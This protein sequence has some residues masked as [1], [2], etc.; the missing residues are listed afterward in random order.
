MNQDGRSATMTAPHGPSQQECIR[1]SLAQ[2]G[3]EA[4]Q[5]TVAE[6]HGTGT[7]LGD[8]IEVNALRRVVSDRETPMPVTSSKTFIA[9]QEA[10]AGLAGIGKC[11]LMLLTSAASPNQHLHYLNSHLDTAGFP[12]FFEDELT[13]YGTPEGLAGVSSF[14]SGG[15]NGRAD[16]WGR[17][18]YGE[19][20]TTDVTSGLAL[21]ARSQ[22]YERICNGE[23]AR[24]WARVSF[25]PGSCHHDGVSMLVMTRGFL[26]DVAEHWE[27]LRMFVRC[28]CVRVCRHV[29]FFVFVFLC[30]Y[31]YVNTIQTEKIYIYTGTHGSIH[32]QLYIF[33][34]TFRHSFMCTF[35]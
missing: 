28:V 18:L 33:T 2:S 30:T 14:G 24:G 9:H 17:C 4:N 19:R 6:C 8:P 3:V 32:T 29:C 16:L 5:I 22:F 23:P 12:A 25:A 35:S 13:D 11:L 26:V 34:F 1:K 31:L 10:G 7:A 20:A 27:S 21:E 15:T